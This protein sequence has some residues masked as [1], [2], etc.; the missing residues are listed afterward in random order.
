MQLSSAYRTSFAL[1]SLLRL[2]ALADATWFRRVE[3]HQEHSPQYEGLARRHVDIEKRMATQAPTAVRKMSEDPRE[4]FFLDYWEF[5]DMGEKL[6]A[7]LHDI[8]DQSSQAPPA[9]QQELQRSPNMSIPSPPLPP[10]LLHSDDRTES[11]FNFRLFPRGL[12]A[13]R[14]FQCPQNTNNCSSINRPN[15][16]CNQDQE[17]VIIPDT[18][19]G[20]VGCCAKGDSCSGIV[21]QCETKDGYTSCPGSPNGG[22][23][24][25][26][27]TCDG[28]GCK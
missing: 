7:S 19:L 22:C 8:H 10:L 5:D 11:F 15:N 13:P 3:A 18:G 1:V 9:L 6:A 23:C 14:S 24:I 17:C 20:D 27:Y 26:N 16:C 4:M 12:L 2:T 21:S 28:V 25:P